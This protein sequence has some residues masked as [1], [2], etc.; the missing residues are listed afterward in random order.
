MSKYDELERKLEEVFK[1]AEEWFEKDDLIE[2]KLIWSD[3]KLNKL[4]KMKTRALEKEKNAY[5]SNID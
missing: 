3:I 5:K 4:F 1:W 2:L